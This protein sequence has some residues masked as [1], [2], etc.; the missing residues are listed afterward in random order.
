[1]KA[2][3]QE[4]IIEIIKKYDIETQDELT[5]KLIEAGFHTTQ[6]TISR[7]IREMKLTKLTFPDGKQKYIALENHGAA[8]TDKY[9]RVLKDGI[10][11]IAI[12]ENILVIR[13]VPGMAMACGAALDHL[14]LNSVLGCIA[15]DDTIMCIAKNKDAAPK[16]KEEIVSMTRIGR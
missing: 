12:S 15:G 13:T 11:N 5:E 8:S 9:K 7:D 14:Q 10:L 16:A 4:K 6:A 1:M 2:K 3:R